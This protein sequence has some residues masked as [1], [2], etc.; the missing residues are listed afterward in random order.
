MASSDVLDFETLLSPIS[1]DQPA[2]PW[3]RDGNEAC[4]QAYYYV[5]DRREDARRK[6]RRI[7]SEVPDEENSG[8]RLEKPDWAAVVQAAND[9][10]SSHTKDL[11]IVAWLVEAL[12]REHGFAGLRDGFRLSRQLCEMYWDKIHPRPETDEDGIGAT[13]A[14]LAV[15]DSSLPE[16]IRKISITA[17]GRSCQDYDLAVE[18]EAITEE[19]A[20]EQYRKRGVIQLA[21]FQNSV[22]ETGLEA[23]QTTI[24]DCAASRDEFKRLTNFLDDRCGANDRGELLSPPSSSIDQTLEA[25]LERIEAL[26]KP[27]CEQEENHQNG[28]GNGEDGPTWLG[29]TTIVT[30]KQQAFQVMER[31]ADFFERTEPTSPVSYLLRESIRLGRLPLPELLRKLDKENGLKALLSGIGASGEVND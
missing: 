16:S 10:L 13:V 1:N 17:S 7:L 12:T 18:L 29:S 8:E 21:E 15:L 25:C 14:Q 9:A 26:A 22:M 3:W 11:W 5:K 2:G 19:T 20:R 4:L 23:L 24:D 27:L 31:I 28:K 30:N 6:R